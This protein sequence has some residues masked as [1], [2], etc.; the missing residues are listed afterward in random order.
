MEFP[1]QTP[2]LTLFILVWRQLSL[3]VVC[4][5]PMCEPLLCKLCKSP[6]F[7][8]C[9]SGKLHITEVDFFG[10]QLRL[11]CTFSHGYVEAKRL[12]INSPVLLIIHC[13]W[14][15]SLGGREQTHLCGSIELQW[16][17][18]A[19][20]AIFPALADRQHVLILHDLVSS[21]HAPLGRLPLDKGI[22]EAG[23]NDLFQHK[24]QIKKQ[25]KEYPLLWWKWRWGWTCVAKG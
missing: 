12:V 24:A 15:A 8:P 18:C 1:C 9:P 5:C 7:A 11:I 4:F 16:I 14:L 2:V 6:L 21:Y 3:A 19:V 25:I 13:D 17:Q 22:F 10:D 23:Y 20:Q